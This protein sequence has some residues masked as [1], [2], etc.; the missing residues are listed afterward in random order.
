MDAKQNAIFDF[1]SPLLKS[2]LDGYCVSVIAY[3]QTGK[4]IYTICHRI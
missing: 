1:V 4:N 3:G 2:A